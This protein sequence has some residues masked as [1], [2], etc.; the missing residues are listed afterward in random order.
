MPLWKTSD[1][2][3]G[4]IKFANTLLSVNVNSNTL[5]ANTT[6]NVV[7]DGTTISVF[8]IDTLEAQAARAKGYG[9]VSPGWVQ[10]TVAGSRTRF[11]TI[12]AAKQVT[13]DSDANT[14][15]NTAIAVTSI[16]TNQ[17]VAANSNT[18]FTVSVRSFPANATLS[19]QWEANTGSGYANVAA[20]FANGDTATLHLNQANSSVNNA[21]VRVVISGSGFA[22]VTSGT[23]T[24]R[25]V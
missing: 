2:A 9:S 12:V 18:T 17:T 8:G 4:V 21:V 1:D 7:A 5:L 3:N 14:M 16:P 20:P 24:I 10:R 13:G 6:A 23:F 19:Y 25:V 11:E 22:N 15:P